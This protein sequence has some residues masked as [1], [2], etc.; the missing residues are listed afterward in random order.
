MQYVVQV[1]LLNIFD[2]IKS[3]LVVNVEENKISSFGEM[4]NHT[5]ILYSR[6]FNLA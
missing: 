3:V 5:H 6:F 1:V 2:L 4:I